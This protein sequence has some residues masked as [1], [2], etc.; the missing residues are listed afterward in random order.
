M[1][2]PQCQKAVELTEGERLCPHCGYYF[3]HES[4]YYASTAP[5]GDNRQSL[6][7]EHLRVSSQPAI[8]GALFALGW[9]DIVVVC[10]GLLYSINWLS[11]LPYGYE[12][13]PEVYG[14]LAAFAVTG[15]TSAAVLFGFATLLSNV[16]AIKAHLAKSSQTHAGHT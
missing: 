2:C 8:I 10:G 3:K 13:S 14:W 4:G 11:A 6:S 12:P 9:V 7:S 16:V 5:A 15:L 1:I